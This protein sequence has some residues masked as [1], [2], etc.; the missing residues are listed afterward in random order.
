M[1]YAPVQIG[2]AAKGHGAFNRMS[3][4]EKLVIP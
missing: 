2:V 4:L 1:L 3:K